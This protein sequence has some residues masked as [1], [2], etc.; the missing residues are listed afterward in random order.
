M[1]SF[2]T[3]IN[4]DVYEKDFS[5]LEEVKSLSTIED[6][7]TFI[8]T[9]E[10]TNIKAYNIYK[11]LQYEEKYIFVV[12]T[13][14]TGYDFFKE[15]NNLVSFDLKL[16]S[17]NVKML[18]S[19]DKSRGYLTEEDFNLSKE[20]STGD[21]SNYSDDEDTSTGFLNP[22]EMENLGIKPLESRKLVHISTGNKLPINDEHGVIIG[23]SSSVA[24]Y[25]IHNTNVS[26]RHARVY[27]KGD[28]YMVHDYN[29]SNGTYVD[30]LKVN[31]NLD[32]EIAVNSTLLIANEEF[33]LI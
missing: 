32:R 25:L 9:F 13:V 14:N 2:I 22:E 5:N 29:S 30:G 8:D 28:K 12:D 26:R 7:S 16:S 33:K 6:V 10:Y 31:E 19:K 15:L 4:K 17:R 20:V 3:K 24:E 23:R 11:V 27:K 18:C 1:S 21:L